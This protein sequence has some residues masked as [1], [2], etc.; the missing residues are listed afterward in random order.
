MANVC[1]SV[2]SSV[3]TRHGPS[4]QNVSKVLR[5][6][7]PPPHFNCQSRAGDII[8]AGVAEDIR[9]CVGGFGIAARLADDH[10]EFALVIDFGAGRGDGNLDLARRDSAPC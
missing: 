10:G 6:H 4:G 1:G 2:I 7:C 3:V 5:H 9:Q 8:A